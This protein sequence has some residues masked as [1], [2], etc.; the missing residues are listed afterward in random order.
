[1][2]PRSDWTDAGDCVNVAL[3]TRA[4]SH[5]TLSLW[6]LKIYVTLILPVC[7]VFITHYCFDGPVITVAFYIISRGYRRALFNFTSAY[8]LTPAL[9]AKGYL[10]M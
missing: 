9:D 2:A 6:R 10:L 1:M 4:V 3:L 8:V 7:P 5:L